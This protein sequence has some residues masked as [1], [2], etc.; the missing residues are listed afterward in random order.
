[1]LRNFNFKRGFK[2][3]PGFFLLIFILVIFIVIF[4]IFCIKGYNSLK[5]NI[6]DVIYR[7]FKD[8]N[9]KNNDN[10]IIKSNKNKLTKKK[11]EK[12][13]KNKEIK[14]QNNSL[15][16]LKSNKNNNNKY[17]KNDFY[18]TDYELNNALYE[19]A[20]RFDKRSGCEYYY[21]L[22]K[23]KQMFIF[24]FLTFD[25]YNSGII[26]KFIFFLLF[27]IHYTINALCFT[28]SNMHQIFVDQGSYNIQYQIKFI[29]FSSVISTAILRIIL[30]TLVLTDKSI[31]EIKRQVDLMHA[32]ILKKNTLKNMKIKFGIF[33]VLN[34]ILLVLFWYYLTCWNAVYKNTDI[35]LIKNTLISFAISL[36]Y[37]FIINIIPVILRKQSLKNS[38]RECLFNASKII[39]LF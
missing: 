22:L 30:I 11:K 37:P 27:A 5:N 14:K 9:N 10:N 34:L 38:K 17:I 13:N 33:F 36:V 29:I 6:E 12:R 7:R 28:D 25:D 31:F 23:S 35:Y 2:I 15:K 24:T 21:S 16:E 26:K 39:Q 20:K 18:E 32:N 19:D 3:N 4:I 1:M 8:K